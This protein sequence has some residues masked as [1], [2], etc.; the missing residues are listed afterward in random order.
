MKNL[1]KETT[2]SKTMP[3]NMKIKTKVVHSKTKV[4]WNVIATTLGAKHKIC[5]VPYFSA[6]NQ[7]LKNE[8]LVHANYISYCFNN[9]DSISK[10]Y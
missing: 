3:R 5:S 10:L 6:N 8:A 7:F 2:Q 4:A 9:S 1:N